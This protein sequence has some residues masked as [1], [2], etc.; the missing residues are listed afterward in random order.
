[1]FLV[2]DTHPWLLR[3]LVTCV[4]KKIKKI[5]TVYKEIRVLKVGPGTGLD[6]V[7][8]SKQPHFDQFVLNLHAEALGSSEV[9]ML[10][11]WLGGRSRLSH[12]KHV[13]RQ[14]NR[15]PAMAVEINRNK[16]SHHH[17][18]STLPSLGCHLV[19]KTTVIAVLDQLMLLNAS[20]YVQQVAGNLFP[21]VC[22]PLLNRVCTGETIA[23]SFKTMLIDKTI[24]WSNW[25][26][27]I[28]LAPKIKWKIIH[29]HPHPWHTSLV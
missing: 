10:N 11:E 7:H 4:S 16:S 29:T 1:M 5:N 8:S 22:H 24:K 9:M 18:L 26:H 25:R 6:S 13:S 2:I 27:P 28:W 17:N 23:R 12:L 14:S 20:N 3:I 21:S 19:I 15:Y